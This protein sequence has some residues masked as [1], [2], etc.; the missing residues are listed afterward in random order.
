MRPKLSDPPV[1]EKLSL[2]AEF[3]PAPS[4]KKNVLCICN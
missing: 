1:A 2:L 4:E 3:D